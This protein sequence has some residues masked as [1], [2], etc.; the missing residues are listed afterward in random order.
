MNLQDALGAIAARFNLDVDA[1]L[2]Y[3]AEDTIGGYPDT[4]PT[5]IYGVEGQV[6]YALAAH[7]GGGHLHI[8]APDMRGSVDHLELAVQR[9]GGRITSTED[10][11]AIDQSIDL[12]FEDMSGWREFAWR[13][14]GYR[15]LR[16]GGFIV[17]H[18]VLHPSVGGDV[19]RDIGAAGFSD[20]LT[21]LIEP[22]DCGLAIWQA[23]GVRVEPEKIHIPISSPEDDFEETPLVI[24]DVAWYEPDDLDAEVHT[25]VEIEELPV[26]EP[27][28]KAKRT[29]KKK[30]AK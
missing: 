19:M 13:V 17:S 28:P 27:K 3:A 8:I 2:H 6:L 29:R 10:D 12:I 16:P 25:P 21:L 24:E 30:A 26:P 11:R 20:V 23:P 18:D 1:L 15:L 9:Y 14:G 22:S 4:F 7:I 5:G